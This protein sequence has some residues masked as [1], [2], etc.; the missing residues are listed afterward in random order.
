MDMVRGDNGQPIPLELHHADQMLGSAIH[1]VDPKTH[2]GPGVHGQ[3]NQGV[4]HKMRKENRELHWKLRGE[5]MS[6]K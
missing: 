6:S 3:K 5:E 4:T 1:E 2:R